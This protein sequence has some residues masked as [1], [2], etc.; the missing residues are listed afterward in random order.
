[1]GGFWFTMNEHYIVFEVLFSSMED[2]K[3]NPLFFVFGVLYESH[4][5]NLVKF[6]S[7]VHYKWW[8]FLVHYEWALYCVWSFVHHYWT[9]IENKKLFNLMLYYVMNEYK[10]LSKFYS[11]WINSKSCLKIV[12]YE[13]ERFLVLRIS[14]N[15][16]WEIVVLTISC[17][18]MWMS[19]K[20]CLTMNEH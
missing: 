2:W 12:H 8:G 9:L 20:F 7:F 16:M 19:I 11:L 4:F 1:M 17:C 6:C 3:N 14:F 13:W 5:Y 18:M 10:I 15:N